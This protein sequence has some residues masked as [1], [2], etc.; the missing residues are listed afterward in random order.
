MRA[1]IGDNLL[2][3]ILATA[4]ELVVAPQTLYLVSTFTEALNRV[5]YYG[6]NQGV[7]DKPIL[8][9]FRLLLSALFSPTLIIVGQVDS[10]VI[11]PREVKICA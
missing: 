8:S 1:K 7:L 10:G 11:A 9:T 6:C 4:S 3:T 2:K 5:Y